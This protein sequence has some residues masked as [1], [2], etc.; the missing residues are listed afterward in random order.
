MVYNITLDMTEVNFLNISEHKSWHV[1]YITLRAEMVLEF[2]KLKVGR[3]D[4]V[5]V[6]EIILC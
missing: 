1:K 4:E 6:K 2:V 3:Q 5:C